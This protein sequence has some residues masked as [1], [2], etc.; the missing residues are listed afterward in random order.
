LT[1][2][3]VAIKSNNLDLYWNKEKWVLVAN[4]LC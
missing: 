4:V 3:D 2:F 1:V